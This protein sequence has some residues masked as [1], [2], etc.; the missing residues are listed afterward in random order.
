[1]ALN[2]FFET[3]LAFG[4][5]NTSWSETTQHNFPSS[6]VWSRPLLQRHIVYDDDSEAN[7]YV[8]RTVAGGVTNN[9]NRPG[10]AIDNC[11]SVTFGA[12]ATEAYVRYACVTIF[13]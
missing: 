4:A 5:I 13:F 9:A 1:M 6:R 7:A 10:V 8:T 3:W 12:K 2:S 11:T